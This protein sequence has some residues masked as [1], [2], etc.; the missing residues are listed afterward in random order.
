MPLPVAAQVD[1]TGM[2]IRLHWDSP[3]FWRAFA[4]A[5]GTAGAVIGLTV[6]SGWLLDAGALKSLHPDWVAMKANTA[7]GF[8]FSGLALCVKNHDAARL[9]PLRHYGGQTLAGIVTLI[10]LLTLLEYASGLDLRIDQL[11]FLE[12]PGAIKTLAPGRMAPASAL[13]FLTLG[14][15]LAVSGKSP[16]GNLL[17]SILAVMTAFPA[18]AS[19]LTYLYGI[20]NAYGLGYGTQMALHTVLAFLALAAGTLCLQ[21]EYGIIALLRSRDTGGVIARRLLPAA[22]L[23]PV[24]I[25]GLKLS[26]DRAKLFEPDFGVALVALSYVIVL[27][28][29]IAWSARLLSRADAERNRANT[30]I[31]E[32]EA[33]LHLLLHTIPDLVWLKDPQGIYLFCNSAFERFAGANEANIVGKSDYDFV[34]AETADFFRANDLAAI[35]SNGPKVNEEWL[36][37]A[38]D[39]HRALVETTKTPMFDNSGKLLGVLGIARD[40]TARHQAEQLAHAAQ[41]Q[42]QRLL[43]EANHSRLALLSILEDQKAAEAEIQKLNTELEQRVRVRTAELEA[44]NK[45]LESFSYSVSHDLRAPLRAISGFAQILARRHRDS[46]NEEG[47]H[48]LNNVV[49]AS[50]RMGVLIEDLLHYSRT[51]RGGV[52]AVPVALSPIVRQL[53]TTFSERIAASG[54]QFEVVEP[55]ATPLGDATLIGQILT[56]LLDNALIY[57]R[58]GVT[59]RITLSARHEDGKV[60][61]RVSDNGIGIAPA[62]HEKIF[63]VFQRLHSEEE[64]P[65]T[66]IGLSIVYKAVRMMEGEI[67]IESTPGAG[68]TF[69]VRLPAATEERSAT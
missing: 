66:G 26:G 6:L 17:S 12:P 51:G 42:S 30:V 61:L 25:G 4:K 41:A 69:S 49:A 5:G 32:S 13:G 20:E 7:L 36:T 35:A 55:L 53:R 58:A 60:V 39:G 27:N 19:G 23:L 64:Y 40:I 21:P 50:E 47:R 37:F 52:R 18:L 56:N 33:R 48:Y 65:G 9:T 38:D 62:Y 11:L 24:L 68:S 45:E 31:R 34:D 46:L 14:I 57:R 59:P 8:L 15:A 2:T 16:K 54:A 1:E 28:V 10:G 67:G 44:A 3:A 43:E 63:Q 22:I 29:L